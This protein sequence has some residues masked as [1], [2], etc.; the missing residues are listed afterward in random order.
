MGVLGCAYVLAPRSTACTGIATQFAT[1]VDPGFG[2]GG[3]LMRKVLF[4]NIL[5]SKPVL[6]SR[7]SKPEPKQ[8]KFKYDCAS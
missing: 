8:K 6:L 3:K 4:V 2:P 1:E 7:T 5:I